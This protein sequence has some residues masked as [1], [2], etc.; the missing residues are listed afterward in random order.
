MTASGDLYDSA[1]P[2]AA[3]PTLPMGTKV[4]IINLK[5]GLRGIARINDR[6][7]YIGRR[8][9]DLSEGTARRLAMIDDGL[10]EVLII[11][12]TMAMPSARPGIQD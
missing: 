8:V 11:P 6:G 2:T 3:H 10:T 5:N 9:I 4:L 7:P 1:G 12:I